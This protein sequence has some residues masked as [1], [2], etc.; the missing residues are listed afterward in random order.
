MTKV[1]GRSKLCVQKEVEMVDKRRSLKEAIAEYV[2][3][4]L[5]VAIEGFTAFI[6]ATAQPDAHSYDP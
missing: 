6:P 3:D 4:D 5:S 1:W 2:R